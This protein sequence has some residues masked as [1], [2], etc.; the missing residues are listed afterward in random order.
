[1]ATILSEVEKAQRARPHR[2]GPGRKIG[3]EVESRADVIAAS[4][5]SDKEAVKRAIDTFPKRGNV[6]R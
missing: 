4:G 5:V 3:R 2:E 1:M 6:D